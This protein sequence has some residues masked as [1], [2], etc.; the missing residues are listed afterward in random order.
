MRLG[1]LG[2]TFDPIHIGHLRLGIEA[3]EH[4]SLDRLVFEV[5]AVSP[6]KTG[7]PVTDGSVRTDMVSAAIHGIEKAE[8]GVQELT[9]EG[10]SYTVDTL[11]HYGPQADEIVL[12]LGS[13]AL[14]AFERWKD[15]EG[16]LARAKLAVSGRPGFGVSEAMRHL[17]T[18]WHQYV[19]VFGA[20]PIDLS[21][22]EI[23]SKVQKGLSI[24]FLTPDP[25]VQIIK[26]R[27]LY[28]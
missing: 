11:D 8:V 4:L 16:I 18:D 27:R 28:V 7:M 10:P 21:A 20:R 15:P 13:D 26:E 6:F 19:T 24:R 5:A 1:I 14:A 9:R 22:T 23:R 12:I 17:P 3:V 25:V 2:G